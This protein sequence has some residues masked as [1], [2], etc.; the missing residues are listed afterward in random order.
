M[1][2]QHDISTFF[3]KLCVLSI[4]REDYFS[5]N[6]DAM[7]QTGKH[8]IKVANISLRALLLRKLTC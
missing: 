2:D 7:S 6:L 1:S 8:C 4:Q 3:L 5:K